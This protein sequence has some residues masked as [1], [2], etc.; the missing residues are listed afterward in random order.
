MNDEPTE[1]GPKLTIVPSRLSRGESDQG[2]VVKKGHLID[3]VV[4]ASGHPKKTVKEISEALL[5][6]LGTALT[7]RDEFALSPLGRLKVA[8][9]KDQGNAEVLVL[10]LRR[11]KKNNMLDGNES[12]A[13][14]QEDD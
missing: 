14:E 1:S 13:S 3:R 9:R 10:R 4:S 11:P 7:E 2:D 6:E 8:K 5:A 12:L